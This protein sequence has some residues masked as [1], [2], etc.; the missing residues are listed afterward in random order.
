MNEYKP[1]MMSYDEVCGIFG[2]SRR[3]IRRWVDRGVLPPPVND[4]A[5]YVNI[6][7][8]S[9]LFWDRKTME[10]RLTEMKVSF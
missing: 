6:G 7:N 3:T 4:S 2:K 10:A 1:K 8:T 9:P 5:A